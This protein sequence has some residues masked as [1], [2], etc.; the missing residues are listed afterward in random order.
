MVKKKNKAN[1]QRNKIRKKQ[2]AVARKNRRKSNMGLQQKFLSVGRKEVR[3]API[4]DIIVPGDLEGGNGMWY[5]VVS[6]ALSTGE[7]A[8]GCF[9]MDTYCLGVK[10][11]FIKVLSI[12]AYN[13]M[14]EQITRHAD[15]VYD[16]SPAYA[17]K[18]IDD[19]VAYARNLGFAP[20]DDFSKT[21]TIVESIDSS[22]CTENFT[23]GKD[24]KPFF[25][26]GPN[27]TP[28]KSAIIMK[29]LEERCGADGFYYMLGGPIDAD[30]LDDE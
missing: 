8:V 12:S 17:R 4:H 6:R 28:L 13:E 21:Y 22:E 27:D 16:K 15:Y 24:G 10:N 9:L 18:F 19:A 26:S 3:E 30:W 29:T 20:G 1:V 23:F 2:R 5:V 11:T 14:C 25:M 7:I